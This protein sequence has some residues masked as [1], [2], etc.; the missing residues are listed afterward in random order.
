MFSQGESAADQS[1]NAIFGGSGAR[2]ASR[3]VVMS[4]VPERFQ[5]NAD[6]VADPKAVVTAGNARF[7][8][9]TPRCVRMEW[10]EDGAFEDRPSRVFWFR[11]Q[12]VPH[13]TVR[14]TRTGVTVT[15]DMLSIRYDSTQHG[16]TAKNLTVSLRGTTTRWRPGDSDPA[17]LGGTGRTLDGVNGPCALATGLLSRN[18][19]TVIDDSETFIFDDNQWPVSRAG[20]AEKKQDLYAF[21]YGTDYQACLCDYTALSGSVPLIPRWALGNW[22]SRYWA[23]SDSELTELMQQFRRRRIPLSVCVIDMDWH[24]VKNP[25]SGGWTGYTWNK[26]YFP[27][28]AAFLKR[29]HQEYDLKISLNLHPADGVHPHEDAYAKMAR[30][31]GINPRGKKPVPF[32][33]TDPRFV[34]GYFKYL[35]HPHEKIGIDFWWMDWQQGKRTAMEGVDPLFWL[36]HLHFLDLARDG[37]RR[38]FVFSRWAG[39]GNHRYQIG[40]SGDTIVSWESLAFQ[41]HFTAT[42][43]NVAYTWWSHDIGG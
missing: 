13:F 28:P 29:M 30:H 14:R 20:T 8:V 39:L 25:Y 31:M 42:A 36:N 23:Y 41:P 17:N 33:C 19:L 2:S 37:S 35:H 34:D 3:G 5:F 12:P 43:S 9:L 32:D 1:V 7:T 11:H 6:P 15:T 38:P 10:S 26:E 22:W 16:F 4:R 24:V 18:G 21:A 40:F 27:Q